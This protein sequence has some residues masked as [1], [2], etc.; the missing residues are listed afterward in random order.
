MIREGRASDREL[1]ALRA[2]LAEVCADVATLAKRKRRPVDTT[3]AA[4][5]DQYLIKLV[6]GAI[7]MIAF[8]DYTMLL[9]RLRKSPRGEPAGAQCSRPAPK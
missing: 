5:E 3:R 1:L 4:L 8:I 7:L 2:N 9:R 6:E